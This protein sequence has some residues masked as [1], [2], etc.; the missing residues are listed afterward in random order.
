M[1][2]PDSPALHGVIFDMDGVLVDSEPFICEAAMRMFEQTYGQIVRREDFA[3]FVG[4]GEDRFIG[5]VAEKYGVTLSMPRDKF[6]TYEIYLDIIRGRLHPLPG[7][8]GFVHLVKS[9]GLKSAVATSA[10]R[11]KM[12]GNLREIKLSP[13]NF[14]A[15]VTGDDVARKKPDP[16]IFLLA[17]SRLNVP[18][19]ECLVI[20][21]A[22]NGIMA[23]KAAGCRC[24]GL[25]SSFTEQT[26]R[27]AGADDVA[28]DLSVVPPA[29]V[30]A[31]SA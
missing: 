3:P 1:R 11:V 25:M 28:K 24:L 20:E 27:D 31:M 26:L 9:R 2:P 17:A 30:E 12:E 29:V 19:A 5:G 16:A 18:P 13:S 8:I 22:P 21:D 7:A 10:D 15:I 6:R 23:A 14:D 4:A